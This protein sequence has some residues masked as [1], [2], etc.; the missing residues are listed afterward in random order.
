[1]DFY[2]LDKAE[3]QFDLKAYDTSAKSFSKVSPSTISYYN[4]G[5]AYY[6]AKKY[7]DAMRYFGAIETRDKT[8]KKYLF[9]NMGNCAVQLKRY[10]R[11]MA[12]Y[13][14]A[15]TLGED[16]DARYNLQLLQKLHLSNKVNVSDMLPQ[17]DPVTKKS[18]SKK[19]DT[20]QDEKKEGKKSNSTSNQQSNQSSA[21]SGS[22]KKGETKKVH[23]AQENSPSK[24]DYKVGYKLYELIN[25]GYTDEKEPW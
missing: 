17:K 18:S 12:Y 5:V 20:T 14:Q 4:I 23:K 2:Y 25:K 16:K 7:K 11:A 9:Y 24:S 6:K 15:L 19:L 3:K 10:D 8:L 21:G 22:S 13:R 1:M